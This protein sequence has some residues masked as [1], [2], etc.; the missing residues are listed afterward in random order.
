MPKNKNT[1]QFF[2]L[3]KNFQVFLF[4]TVKMFEEF[5]GFFCLFFNH[6]AALSNM[7]A[8]VIS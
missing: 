7:G 5:R 3:E 2:L 1:G 8:E 6:N 4:E